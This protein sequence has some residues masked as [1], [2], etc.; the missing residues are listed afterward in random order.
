[1]RRHAARGNRTGLGLLGLGLLLA[2]A[3]LTTVSLGLFGHNN[4]AQPIYPPQAQRYIH[5]HSWIWSVVA[6]TAV[7]IGLLCLRWLLVQPRRDT[8][9]QVR[10]DSDR[11]SEPGAGRTLVLS[12]AVA[13]IAED[14]LAPQSGVRRVSAA[15]SGS[16][17]QPEIWITLVADPVANL[18]H[19]RDHLS[20]KSLRSIR[21]ALGQ[22]QLTA[23][24]SIT[25]RSRR[26]HSRASKHGILIGQG[27]S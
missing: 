3:A 6:A 5:E 25:V 20:E 9:R 7:I 10:I 4:A 2:G 21:S 17:D 27:P 18:A 16:P 13:N 14:E 8:L 19:L 22:P 1:M 23:Y 26:S 12:A 15:L 11:T 24:L